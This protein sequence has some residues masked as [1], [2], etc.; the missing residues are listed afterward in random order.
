MEQP[1]LDNPWPRPWPKSVPLTPCPA[2]PLTERLREL[3]RQVREHQMAQHRAGRPELVCG[4]FYNDEVV[5]LRAG[6][7]HAAYLGTDGRIHYE[8][9][10]EAK[11]PRVLTDP[12]DVASTIVKCANDIGVPELIELLPPRPAGGEICRLCEGRRWELP[13]SSGDPDGRPW[14]CRRCH[15]LGWTLAEPGST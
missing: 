3:L 10:G 4:V 12:R 11:D 6:G 2:L 5:C 7:G 15:G 14:C 1:T 13:A 8:N 9:Y